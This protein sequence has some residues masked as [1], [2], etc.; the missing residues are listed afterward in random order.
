MTDFELDYPFKHTSYEIPH[1]E[2]EVTRVDAIN[3]L[4]YLLNNNAF[5]FINGES[6]IGKSILLKQ[7][8]NEIGGNVI[9]LFIDSVSSLSITEEAI[10][11][12]VSEQV[13]WLIHGRSNT[14]DVQNDNYSR[15]ISVLSHYVRKNTEDIVFIIDGLDEI[16]DADLVVKVIKLIPFHI[17]GIKFIIS[18]NK[19]DVFDTFKKRKEKTVYYQ[20]PL[21]NRTECVLMLGNG[22]TEDD[23]DNLC[24][25]YQPLP[26]KL[27]SIKRI[28]EKGHSIDKLLNDCGEH[29]SSILDAEWLLN[30]QLINDNIEALCLITYCPFPMELYE[31]SEIVNLTEDELFEVF[32]RFS[33][34][35]CIDKKVEFVNKA[36]KFFLEGKLYKGRERFRDG[37]KS[38]ISS[39]DRTASNI[40][41]IVDYKYTEKDYDGVISE[42]SNGEIV[43]VYRERSSLNTISKLLK[44]AIKSSVDKKFLVDKIKFSHLA[45]LIKG[46]S[47]ISV[48]KSEIDF[49]L[50][51]NNYL[52]ATDLAEE[53]IQDE[54]KIQLLSII[55]GHQKKHGVK[56]DANLISKIEYLYSGLDLQHLDVTT[57]MDIS[58]CIFP[59]FPKLSFEIISHIDKMGASGENK[60]D[61]AYARF[62]FEAVLKNNDDLNDVNFEGMDVDENF[63]QSIK[64][65]QDLKGNLSVDNFIDEIRNLKL[66]DGDKISL[67]IEVVKIFPQHKEVPNLVLDCLNMIVETAEYS[68][69][70]SAYKNVSQCLACH[71]ETEVTSE[72]RKKIIQQ[73]PRLKEIGPTVDYVCVLLNLSAFEFI[74]KQD[75]TR[76]EEIFKYV[77]TEIS[78]YVVCLRSVM[79]IQSSWLK[80]KYDKYFGEISKFKI[81]VFENILTETAQHY[82]VLKESI[83]EEAKVNLKNAIFLSKKLN[84]KSRME[85]AIS[86]AIISHV[87]HSDNVDI[88]FICDTLPFIKGTVEYTSAAFSLIKYVSECYCEDKTLNKSQFDR[89]KKVRNKITNNADRIRYVAYLLCVYMR[90]EFRNDIV[91]RQ[92]VDEFYE[93]FSNVDGDWNKINVGFK[94]GN[95]LS[96]V[97]N[98]MSKEIKNKVI[99]VRRNSDIDAY[100]IKESY[101]K[102]IE[103]I[104]NVNCSIL[105][106]SGIVDGNIDRVIGSVSILSGNIERSRLLSKLISSLQTNKFESQ[107]SAIINSN[108]LC[109]L[110]SYSKVY[111]KE[112]GI[113]LLNIAPCIYKYDKGMF[114]DYLSVINDDA[115]RNE[116]LSSTISY[117]FEKIMLWEPYYY[118][119]KNSYDLTFLDVKNIFGLLTSST[120]DWLIFSHLKRLTYALKVSFKGNNFSEAQKLDVYG[121]YQDVISMFPLV[122]CIQHDGYSICAQALLLNLKKETKSSSWLILSKKA[123]KISN[124][125]DSIYTRTCI[126]E[127]STYL[128]ITERKRA[129]EEVINSTHIINVAVERI[130]LIEHIYSSCKSICV[131][132]VK[133]ALNKAIL[134]STEEDSNEFSSKRKDLINACFDLDEKLSSTISSLTD[135]DPYRRRLIEENINDKKELERTIE[136][137]GENGS[138]NLKYIDQDEYAK[139]CSNQLAK[140]NANKAERRKIA[141]LMKFIENIEVFSPENTHIILKFFLQAYGDNF[142]T[143][144]LCDKHL[145]PIF[146]ALVLNAKDFCEIY[147]IKEVF[148][149]KSEIV[150]DSITL[151]VGNSEVGKS[152]CFIKNWICSCNVT[153]IIISEPYFKIEDLIFIS[154]AIDM[155]FD[156]DIKIL[157]SLESYSE[158]SNAMVNDGGFSD[159]DEYIEK[160]WKENICPDRNPRVE[161]VFCGTANDK[162]PVIHDRWWLSCDGGSGIKIGTSIGGIGKKI[163]GIEKMSHL[164]TLDTLENLNEIFQKNMKEHKGHTTKYKSAMIS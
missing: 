30:E 79:C 104:I 147:R 150:N 93:C 13:S 32:S 87:Q 110:D 31:L 76:N 132:T 120:Q 90:L 115:I 105:K 82:N 29:N 118:V 22:V 144:E 103:L 111:S 145:Q 156:I 66:S 59:I 138:K 44:I 61:Y 20:V 17:S 4:H 48:L 38:I 100:E 8:S 146:D 155:D 34:L 49:Y 41:S 65:I 54:D 39:R 95:I 126:L 91:Q 154:R 94:S 151:N 109:M 40:V 50:S 3:N 35:K 149:P 78:D 159:L 107:A 157:S 52:S 162:S 47:E 24:S 102:C 133:N 140:M 26:E 141:H 148:Q 160:F 75:G 161:F 119:E 62:Y 69:S 101:V 42:L 86:K 9:A 127:L 136:D 89:L 164:G 134:I 81:D 125:A 116:I 1:T 106:S 67:I 73:L 64:S 117:L 85:K 158:L 51:E 74:N 21:M 77:K 129:L 98:D 36:F 72:I 122:D 131:K 25:I 163:S 5:I 6:G 92:L 15:N 139:F 152:E 43:K 45:S 57:S 135:A 71:D 121:M 68:G 33:F 19:Q 153:K 130:D 113:V 84:T 88:I 53:A 63:K 112:Y 18:S 99:D 123:E 142:K 143:K 128:P 12:D 46:V 56:A 80:S 83:E 60:S 58:V 23:V 108:V 97:L 27:S 7:F 16:Q 96:T 28:L 10:K 55:A 137:F 114:E 124:I 2:N 14:D 70:C 11:Y 37:I